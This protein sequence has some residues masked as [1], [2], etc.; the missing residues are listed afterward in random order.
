MGDKGAEVLANSN[1]SN[2]TELSLDD[3]NVG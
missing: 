1:F 3:N 2:L